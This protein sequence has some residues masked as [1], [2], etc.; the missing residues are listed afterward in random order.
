MRFLLPCAVEFFVPCSRDLHVFP[1]IR[2]V[3][4]LY[5]EDPFVVFVRF[6]RFHVLQLALDFENENLFRNKKAQKVA[7]RYFLSLRCP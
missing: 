3:R 2:L 4:A 5:G 7:T 1:P 6:H